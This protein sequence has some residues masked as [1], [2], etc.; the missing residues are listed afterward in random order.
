MLNYTHWNTEVNTEV[1]TKC[2]KQDVQLLTVQDF[3][4][5]LRVVLAGVKEGLISTIIQFPQ[6]NNIIYKM[7]HNQTHTGLQMLVTSQTHED[8]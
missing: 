6:L 5:H 3:K 1:S 4:L 8:V 7:I 2:S